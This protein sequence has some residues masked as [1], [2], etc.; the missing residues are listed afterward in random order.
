MILCFELSMPSCPSWNGKWSGEGRLYAITRKFSGVKG[1]AHAQRIL[2]AAP[3]HYHWDDGW[4]A[5]V[6]VR[7]VDA[8]EAAQ[9]RKKSVGFAGYDWMVESII[10]HGAIYADHQIP[11]KGTA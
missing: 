5:M 4:G 8:K 7:E 1:G 9:A 3:Y 2:D 11:V 10:D 6:R